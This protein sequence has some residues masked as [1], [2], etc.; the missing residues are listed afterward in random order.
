VPRRE[1]DVDLAV[2]D[3][4]DFGRPAMSDAMKVSKP[5]TVS[6]TG[7]CAVGAGLCGDVGVH[8]TNDRDARIHSHVFRRRKSPSA[9]N[10][11]VSAAGSHAHHMSATAQDGLLF[12]L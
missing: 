4:V 11:G 9:T 12:F 6:G 5:R 10:N 7:L 2:H 8:M 1:I 3:E